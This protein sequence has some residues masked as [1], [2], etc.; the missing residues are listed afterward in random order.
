ME[1]TMLKP[2]DENTRNKLLNAVRKALAD[3]GLE[4]LLDVS[5]ITLNARIRPHPTC[6]DGTPAEWGQVLRPDGTIVYGWVCK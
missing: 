3:A 2:P 1:Q 5:S 6:P 4:D